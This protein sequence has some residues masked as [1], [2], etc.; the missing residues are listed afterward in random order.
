[1]RPTTAWRKKTV[2]HAHPSSLFKEGVVPAAAVLTTTRLTAAP[3]DAALEHQQREYAVE[4]ARTTID[5]GKLAQPSEMTPLSRLVNSITVEQMVAHKKGDAAVVYEVRE[6]EPVINAIELMCEKRIGSVIVRGRETQLHVGM[7]SRIDC[8]RNLVLKNQFARETPI[9]RVMDKTISCVTPAFT[10]GQCLEIMAQGPDVRYLP[11]VSDLGDWTDDDTRVTG[12]L[13]QR[14]LLNWF[15]RCFLDAGDADILDDA[16]RASAS[17][18]F[19]KEEGGKES[20]AIYVNSD[21][22]VFDALTCMAKS[23]QTYVVVNKGQEMVGIFTGTD[24]LNKIIRPG[25]K[26]KNTNIMDVV[27]TEMVVAAPHYTLIDC[28]SLM[29]Q[30]EIQHLPIGE[31]RQMTNAESEDEREGKT[32]TAFGTDRYSSAQPLGVITAYD[33][34]DYLDAQPKMQE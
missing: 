25:R 17:D 5:L 29:L 22:T 16:D 26:S 28:I 14:D 18:L 8:M 1:L 27:S 31:W 34:I 19:S 2:D 33:C 21:A 13:G 23:N 3:A 12:I 32:V 15:V 9:S 24:Y 7:M 20:T 10:L 11:V 4:L 6:D 30:N